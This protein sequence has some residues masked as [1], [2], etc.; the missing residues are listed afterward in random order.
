MLHDDGDCAS[1]FFSPSKKQTRQRKN[2]AIAQ[3]AL[4]RTLS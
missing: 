1:S 4:R 3:P 2:P